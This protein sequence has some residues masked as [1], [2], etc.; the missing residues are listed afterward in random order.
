MGDVDDIRLSLDK[1]YTD[2]Y[3]QTRLT[4]I[5]GI[6]GTERIA[7]KISLRTIYTIIRCKED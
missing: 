5:L 4:D 7:L 2:S 3:R 1:C 6:H